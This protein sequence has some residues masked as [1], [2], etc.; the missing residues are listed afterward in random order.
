MS[1]LKPKIMASIGPVASIDPA[2]GD[3]SEPVCG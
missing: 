2:L 1:S 3:E